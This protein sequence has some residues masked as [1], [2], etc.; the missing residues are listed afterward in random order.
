MSISAIPFG[1]VAKTTASLSTLAVGLAVFGAGST[2]AGLASAITNFTDPNWA[3]TIVQNV[4]TLSTISAIPFGNV[5]EASGALATIAGGLAAFGVGSAIAGAGEAVA[6]FAGGTDWTET[7]K[8]NVINLASIA[9][10]VSTEK[11]ASFSEAMGSISAGL[12]KFSAGNFGA[13]FMEVGANILNFLS[14]NDSPIEQMMKIADNSYDLEVGAHHL[15]E[16]KVH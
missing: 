11:A 2:I 15:K 12:L 9:D 8:Q 14:G 7:T 10:E 5:L 13:A 16:Y 6:K 3:S 1:D 4:T